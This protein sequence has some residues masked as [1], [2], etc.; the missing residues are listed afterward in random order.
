MFLALLW[1]TVVDECVALFVAEEV[2]VRS[3]GEVLVVVVVF[4]PAGVVW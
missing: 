3:D 1:G 4:D 2:D